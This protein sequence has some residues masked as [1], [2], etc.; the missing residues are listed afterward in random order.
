LL[1]TADDI[2]GVTGNQSFNDKLGH[3]RVNAARAVNDSFSL[4]A[5]LLSHMDLRKGAA[6]QVEGLRLFFTEALDPT[7][8]NSSGNYDLRSPGDDG[9]F[10]TVDDHRFTLTVG[11]NFPGTSTPIKYSVNSNYVDLSVSG[12]A[13]PIGDYRFQAIVAG[14]NGLRSPFDVAASGNLQHS[15]KIRNAQGLTGDVIAVDLSA[16]GTGFSNLDFTPLTTTTDSLND[17]HLIQ[18]G[19]E[20]LGKI[21]LSD[22]AEGEPFSTTGRFYLI[23][24][25]VDIPVDDDVAAAGFQGTLQGSVTVDGTVHQFEISAEDGFS[26]TGNAAVTFG[27]SFVENLRV[28]QRLRYLGFPGKNGELLTVDGQL[29][30]QTQHAV[31]LFNSAVHGTSQVRPT[32]PVQQELSERIDLS[33]VNS[34][35]APQWQRL[36][37]VAGVEFGTPDDVVCGRLGLSD[38]CENPEVYATNWAADVLAATGQ[39]AMTAGATPLRFRHASLKAGGETGIDEFFRPGLPQFETYRDSR[40]GPPHD[41]GMQLSFDVGTNDILNPPFYKERYFDNEVDGPYVAAKTSSDPTGDN[42]IVHRI[43][44]HLFSASEDPTSSFSVVI[45]LE[46]SLP[47]LEQAVALGMPIV[48]LT[49][50]IQGRQVTSSV[51]SVDSNTETITLADELTQRENFF[52]GDEIAFAMPDSADRT[53]AFKLQTHSSRGRRNAGN[54]GLIGRQS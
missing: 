28:Q 18:A 31:R 15:F 47:A 16:L 26:K 14:A 13:L 48:V 10:D 24:E 43:F 50:D 12:G 52:F 30:A 42:H 22:R 23:P 34:D 11:S 32:D 46:Q 21:V 25:A 27:T 45:D 41:G 19:V 36:Q 4:T 2:D 33:Y 40:L 51:V 6:G 3:G 20:E 53:T 54:E 29:G 7:S 1:G 44:V 38:G 39:A 8:A 9:M 49:K 17:I 5:P 37:P 35:R